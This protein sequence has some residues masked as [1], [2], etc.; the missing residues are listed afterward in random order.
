MN[1]IK[2]A[3]QWLIT[4]HEK[5]VTV[6]EA[7]NDTDVST[8]AATVTTTT[9]VEPVTTTATAVVSDGVHDF[10]AA[11]QFVLD[12]VEKLGDEAKDELV[13]LAKKYL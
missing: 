1:F 2:R 11:L 4:K 5:E 6:S 8:A 13:A 7:L 12:G 3:W 9:T 10:E